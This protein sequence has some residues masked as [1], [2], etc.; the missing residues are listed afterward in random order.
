M[1]VHEVACAIVAGPPL[2]LCAIWLTHDAI[3]A[4]RSVRAKRTSQ[5]EAR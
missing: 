1:T 2:A 5:Q 4:A 3:V